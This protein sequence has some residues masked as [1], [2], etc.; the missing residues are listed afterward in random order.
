MQPTS[1]F[2]SK[3]NPYIKVSLG[4]KEEKDLK[5]MNRNTLN[6]EF[7][8]F[9]EFTTKIPGP[10]TLK[11]QVFDHKKFFGTDLCMGETIIDCEDRFFHPK[12]T[13]LGDTKPVEVIPFDI[14]MSSMITLAFNSTEETML[15]PIQM[16]S[17]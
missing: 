10:S 3:A 16:S 17:I 11:L 9:Y 2:N 5:T 14:I 7:Y 8:S 13:E 12:W 1:F 15:V 6:P 4:D